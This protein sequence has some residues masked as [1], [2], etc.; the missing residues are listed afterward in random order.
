MAS[1]GR[2][3]I[4]GGSQSQA[5]SQGQGGSQDRTAAWTAQLTSIIQARRLSGEHPNW[6]SQGGDIFGDIPPG[7]AA[8]TRPEVGLAVCSTCV[9]APLTL[10][11]GIDLEA[12]KGALRLA[13][14]LGHDA[15]V[16]ALITTGIDVNARDERGQ[17]ALYCAAAYDC[18]PVVGRAA[19]VELLLKVPGIDLT[20]QGPKGTALCVASGRCAQLPIVMALLDALSADNGLPQHAAAGTA[21]ADAAAAAAAAGTAPAPAS[22][23][24]SASASATAAAAATASSASAT[25][26]GGQG[27]GGQDATTAQRSAVRVVN[28]VSPL[29]ETPLIAACAASGGGEAALAL[30]SEG[31][32]V[33]CADNDGYTPLHHACRRGSLVVAT[34]LLRHGADTRALAKDGAPPLFLAT[35]YPLMVKQ[36]ILS[37]CAP[38]D[39]PAVELDMLRSALLCAAKCQPAHMLMIP[40]A[41][42]ALVAAG[43]NPNGVD[44]EGRPLL[45]LAIHD[46]LAVKALLRA[47]ADATRADKSGTTPMMAAKAGGFPGAALIE[48][49]LADHAEG[50]LFPPP[51][52]ADSSAQT[53][54][55]SAAAAA[56]TLTGGAAAGSA[57]AAA[58]SAAGSA[59][60]GAGG[61]PTLD[62]L[63]FALATSSGLFS[64]VVCN[65]TPRD[66]SVNDPQHPPQQQSVIEVSRAFTVLRYQVNAAFRENDYLASITE[67]AMQEVPLLRQNVHA[68][69]ALKHVAA[70]ST[71]IATLGFTER[72]LCSTLAMVASNSRADDPI[73]Q[74]HVAA[75]AAWREAAQELCMVLHGA[76]DTARDEL[77]K[78]NAECIKASKEPGGSSSSS[79][80][81][82]AAYIA[83]FSGLQK[84]VVEVR[85]QTLSSSANPAE[86]MAHTDRVMSECTAIRAKVCELQNQGY[87]YPDPRV[88]AAKEMLM[89]SLQQIADQAHKAS[90]EAEAGQKA[91]MSAGRNGGAAAPPKASALTSN[92]CGA[93]AGSGASGGGAGGGAF[94][95]DAVETQFMA[96]AK[97][98]AEGEVA[99]KADVAG[100]AKDIPTGKRKQAGAAASVSP[101][102]AAATAAAAAAAADAAA[103]KLKASAAQAAASKAQADAKEVD[104]RA[105]S[106][107]A[108]KEAEDR[109]RAKAEAAEKALLEADAK[110]KAEAEARAKAESQ[111]KLLQEALAKAQQEASAKAK[112]DAEVRAKAVADAKAK[113]KADAKAK[114]AA[115]EAL[116]KAEAAAKLKAERDEASAARAAEKAKKK[117][118]R[119][120]KKAGEG[121]AGGAAGASTSSAAAAPSPSP[122]PSPR[123][124]PSPLMGTSAAPPAPVPL[125]RPPLMQMQ[126]PVM[127]MRPMMMGGGVAPGGGVPQRPP[128]AS[129]ALMAH[130]VLGA[131]LRAAAAAEASAAA[132]GSSGAPA[133]APAPAP[134]QAMPSMAD[135]QRAR[136]A[137]EA[138]RVQQQQAAAPAPAPAAPPAPAAAAAAAAAAR[139]QRQEEKV[140]MTCVVCMD[141]PRSAL[142]LPCSHLNLCKVCCESIRKRTN[143]CPMCRAPIAD[144]VYS[145][146][147]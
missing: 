124:M 118:A 18:F 103:A 51:A 128:G 137:A 106:T 144:V 83:D 64:A 135:I 146:D 88:Q 140:D 85:S 17:T 117:E 110:E 3:Q 54:A 102:A 35:K 65:S 114:L 112:A 123:P 52:A 4:Q 62:A 43:A 139:R 78:V 69:A 68:V 127:A 120:A 9:E 84:R 49:A 99:A 58:A 92:G 101:K 77:A 67:L 14:G 86:V 119:L 22:A 24:A 39:G 46:L 1:Q 79:S 111:A 6:G 66:V 53:E 10:F 44:E 40:E 63:D 98:W 29:G 47:G 91:W 27:Q 33:N 11:A 122:S 115:A 147:E 30:I 25:N 42:A 50:K 19:V 41:I 7:L 116:V 142:L 56:G 132:A 37:T 75:V 141:S 89:V 87:S 5:G 45:L 59:S 74:A 34:A 16:A 55:V 97:L 48:R 36:L 96:V 38:P 100:E 57:A 136:A 113:A 28:L 125:M 131:A 130:P 80:A 20:A 73:A 81:A 8:T 72:D 76:M 15:L 26:E 93:G 12:R 143:E 82:Y 107:A 126:M 60:A 13:A 2:S 94:D 109:A 121:G 90:A 32:E 138:A 70:A 31:A 95:P 133:P 145:L 71:G 23:S 104:A 21:A 134:A 105:K 129:S 108:A 61:D